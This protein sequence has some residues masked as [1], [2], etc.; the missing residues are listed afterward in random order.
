MVTYEQAITQWAIDKLREDGKE[1]HVDYDPVSI[2]VDFDGTAGDGGYS[3]WTPDP[4][5]TLEIR[6]RADNA[7]LMLDHELIGY[8]NRSMPK[9]IGELVE[10]AAKVAK[11]KANR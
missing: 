5:A 11:E 3:E 7:Y 10:A 8:A 4:Y 6:I 1:P 9:L 2:E